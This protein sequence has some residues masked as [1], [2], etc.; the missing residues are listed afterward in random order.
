[1]KFVQPKMNFFL[2]FF[3]SLFK[4][5]NCTQFSFAFCFVVLPF[6]AN[7][8]CETNGKTG[9]FFFST[10]S[11]LSSLFFCFRVAFNVVN[12]IKSFVQKINLQLILSSSQVAHI[13]IL[14]VRRCESRVRRM[15]THASCSNEKRRNNERI[16]NS[17]ILERSKQ[18]LRRFLI[19]KI[20]ITKKMKTKDKT[21]EWLQK[22]RKMTNIV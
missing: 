1:M 2:L 4:K 20:W 15:Q 8:W 17:K 16:K 14:S 21:R 12:N 18:K 3:H 9:N 10:V 22:R 13:F 7:G 19:Y 5:S 11:P 6:I